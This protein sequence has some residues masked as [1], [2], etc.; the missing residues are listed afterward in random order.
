MAKTDSGA[1][2][3]MTS[4]YVRARYTRVRYQFQRRYNDSCMHGTV[5]CC[6]QCTED[7]TPTRSTSGTLYA[8]PHCPLDHSLGSSS[9]HRN[10]GT[11]GSMHGRRDMMVD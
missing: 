4:L 5:A 7:G 11:D 3:N 2:L 1:R 8:A 9:R 10:D 6:A